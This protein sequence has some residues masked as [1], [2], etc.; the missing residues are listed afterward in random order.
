MD[1]DSAFAAIRECLVV[2]GELRAEL[3]QQRVSA[4]AGQM[5]PPMPLVPPSVWFARKASLGHLYPAQWSWTM[6]T[7]SFSPRILDGE[8]GACGGQP[9]LRYS[10]GRVASRNHILH[11]LSARMEES[12]E[13]VS[14][15]VMKGG[16]RE[17]RT[18][19]A[20]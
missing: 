4:S 10:A 5:M 15:Y 19:I 6:S 9:R 14:A 11:R 1:Q 18:M 3:Q 17:V 12:L 16:Q 2:E 20:R 8:R 13:I 7:S